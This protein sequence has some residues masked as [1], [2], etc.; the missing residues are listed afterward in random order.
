V[1]TGPTSI[2]RTCPWCK[3]LTRTEDGKFVEHPIVTQ[4]SRKGYTAKTC[5]GSG[6]SIN[7]TEPT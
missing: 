2:L 1:S 6:K 4:T 7:L 3:E 5:D